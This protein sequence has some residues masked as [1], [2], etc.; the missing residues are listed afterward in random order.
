MKCK[1]KHIYFFLLFMMAVIIVLICVY[2]KM[3]KN[4][5]ELLHS[6][7]YYDEFY[8]NKDKVFLKCYVTIENSSHNDE[9]IYLTANMEEDADNG[10]LKSPLVSGYNKKGSD[11]FF[12]PA[13]SKRGYDVI[14]IG[15]FAG[16]SVKL[17]RR[18]PPIEITVIKNKP[19]GDE[20]K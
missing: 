6:D 16:K 10:L 4:N 5:V 7:S 15:D 18:L 11:K 13:N 8:I 19:K 9:Y 3:K 1:T 17:N 20:V 14:F 2:A 12:I